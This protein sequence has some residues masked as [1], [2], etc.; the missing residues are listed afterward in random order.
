M[1]KKETNSEYLN[2]WNYSDVYLRNLQ[3]ALVHLLNRTMTIS[4]VNNKQEICE[5]KIPFYLGSFSGDS[6]RFLQDFFQSD[7]RNNEI[8]N[9]YIEGGIDVVPRGIIELNGITIKPEENLNK[10]IPANHTVKNQK[11]GEIKTWYSNVDTLQLNVSFGITIK[12]ST[13]IELYKVWQQFMEELYKTKQFEFSYNGTMITAW[14]GLSENSEFENVHE[15]SFG[16]QKKLSI[17]F[18]VEVLTYY[19]VFDRTSS[20]LASQTVNK[21]VINIKDKF[22][23]KEFKKTKRIRNIESED[24]EIE[25]KMTEQFGKSNIEEGTQSLTGI[26]IE[27]SVVTDSRIQNLGDYNKDIIKRPYEKGK[28]LSAK[29]MYTPK[30]TPIIHKP[31]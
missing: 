3:I 16:E 18:D 17:S 1:I 25:V 2:Y 26:E 24:K 6:E 11:T 20:V 23:V 13:L 8:V 10:F 4:Y 19:N 5:Y 31:I 14:L 27:N 9:K 28:E 29:D 15:F 12:C 30:D 22:E 7:Q 21:F